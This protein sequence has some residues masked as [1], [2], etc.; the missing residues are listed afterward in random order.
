MYEV[1]G[2]SFSEFNKFLYG[3]YVT[4]EIY[5]SENQSPLKIGDGTPVPEMFKIH[6]VD[7]IEREILTAISK[8][9]IYRYCENPKLTGMT[10][11]YDGVFVGQTVVQDYDFIAFTIQNI[12]L[13]STIPENAI[14]KLFLSWD[15]GT[16]WHSNLNDTWEI[17]NIKSIKSKGMTKERIEALTDIQLNEIKTSDKIRFAYYL[18]QD[19]T[20][21]EIHLDCMR[22]NYKEGI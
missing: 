18:E 15:S 1:E 12:E 16:T 4:G 9:R 7:I 11:S 14:V 13:A 19:N 22:V 6:G 8:P 20:T 10:Q 2:I 17:F 3:D 21:E 5:T